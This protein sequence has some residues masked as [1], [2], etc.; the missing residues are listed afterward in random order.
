MRSDGKFVFYGS[1]FI[2]LDF[3]QKIIT[4]QSIVDGELNQYIY[5][6]QWDMVILGMSID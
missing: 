3:T 2:D 6:K 1:E 4:D 5:I